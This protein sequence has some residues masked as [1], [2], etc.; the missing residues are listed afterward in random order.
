[1][2]TLSIL[3]NAFHIDGQVPGEHV[4]HI[5]APGYFPWDKKAFIESGRSTEFWNITLIG[6]EYPQIPIAET[7]SIQKIFP[8]PE[9][10]LFALLGTRDGGV[11]VKTL[12]TDTLLASEI[13]FIPNASLRKTDDENLEWSP[14]TKQLLIPLTDE[15]GQDI[16]LLVDVASNSVINL[17]EK[18]G[19]PDMRYAR[20]DGR[21]DNIFYFLAGHTLYSWSSETI[22]STPVALI[23]DISGYDISQNFIYSVDA[24]AGIISRLKTGSATPDS[25]QIT[26]NEIPN[27]GDS[28]ALTVYDEDR[29]A[30]RNRESGTLFIFNRGQEDYFHSLGD[31]IRSVQFSNDGKKLLFGSDTEI[32]VSFIRPWNTQPIRSEDEVL[33]IARFASPIR[34]LQWTKDYEHALFAYDNSIRTVELDHRDR[35]DM[36]TIQTLSRPPE[37]LLADFPGDQL[38]LI[39]QKDGPTLSAIPFPIVPIKEVVTP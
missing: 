12:D 32:F 3:N 1:M 6:K 37:Q 34:F 10:N 7:E 15:H 36:Q 35:R 9:S 25:E 31:G 29:I 22:D 16:S 14:D 21:R 33:Q 5:E 23:P 2:K 39:E 28:T 4:I 13:A 30:I 11:V 24:K 38:F 8:S 19:I 27:E 17:T 26:E 20:W 18:S